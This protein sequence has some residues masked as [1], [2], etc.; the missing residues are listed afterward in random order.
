MEMEKLKRLVERPFG[1]VLFASAIVLGD[2]ATERAFLPIVIRHA[3]GGKAH[4]LCVIDPESMKNDLARA[5]V[6]FAKLVG[7]P[8]LLFSDSDGPGRKDAQALIADLAEGDEAYV[9]WVVGHP[10][11]GVVKSG[12]IERMMVSFDEQLCQDAC[13]ELRPDFD[14]NLTALEMLTRCKG[15]VGATLARRLIEQHPDP[16]LWPDSLRTLSERLDGLL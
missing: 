7:I 13:T 12:A 14:P 16:Q 3:L 4:G 6:K 10:S 11:N 9:V 8:W 1:E 2:G 15:S 5:A